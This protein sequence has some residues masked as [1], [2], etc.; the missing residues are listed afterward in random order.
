M[1]NKIILSKISTIGFKE[2]SVLLLLAM[3]VCFQFSTKAQDTE[4]TRPSW[5]FGVAAGSNF[6][7]YRGTTQNLNADLTVPSAFYNGFGAGLFIA[8]S[9]E[10]YKP[11]SVLGFIFQVGYDD[12]S[13]NFDQVT[14][15][16]NCPADL[17]TRTN[18]ISVEPSLRI[19]PFKN[20]FYVYGGPRLAFN[21][22]NSFKYQLGVNPDVPGQEPTPAVRGDLSNTQETI[23]SM[24]VGA[25]YDIMLSSVK[26]K[27]QFVLSP[28][29]AFHPYYGQNPRTSESW[30]I[31]TVR[32]GFVLKFGQG[33]QVP[34]LVEALPAI[35]PFSFSVNAP[36]N[37]NTEPIVSE[38]FPL[39][40]Y[41]FFDLGSTEIPARYVKLDKSQV[42]DFKEDQLETTKPINLSGRSDRGMIV[43]Y[44]ILNILGDRM[45]KNPNTTIKLVGA[46]EKGPEDGKLMAESVKKY[47]TS[48]FEIAPSRITVEG[49]TKPKLPSEQPGGTLE[50]ELLRQGDR[51][52]SI[53]S[54]SPEL[55]M[56]FQSGANA[57]L[58]PI[59][60]TGTKVAPQSSY[61]TFDLP[62][63]KEAFKVWN[64]EVKDEKG[65]IQHFGPYTEETASIP[66]K[67]ILGSREE[68]D[69]TIAMVGTTPDG[70]TVRE[71]KQAHVVLWKPS[72]NEESKRFSVIYDFNNSDAIKIYEDYLSKV[73]TPKI[74]K[75]GRVVINGFTDVIGD[76]TNNQELSLARANDVKQILEKSL[77]AAGRSDVTFVVTG[78]GENESLAPFDNKLPEERFYNR[79]V[80][81]DVFPAK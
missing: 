60:L 26:N 16:C 42:K 14:T 65:M 76:A 66:T 19:A 12:R 10:Y 44:N 80:I 77:K 32:A 79:T 55:L 24:Q 39:R 73:V 47:L 25:G 81:I 50:L 51:R 17:K 6:N 37:A 64:V 49:R 43:Y 33:K 36:S 52:V 31:T 45:Q 53:E 5:Y 27:T 54:A 74:P 58:K 38:T 69:Y 13:A 41:V 3:L 2:Q 57:P 35:K 18:Y 67:T 20:N 8:P 78:N 11:N 68:G 34:L 30:N 63:A 56:E 40:N 72:V 1:N 75:N 4:Y 9:I 21:L 23:I 59:V 28:F 29:V 46:S 71:E 7:F 48:I 70:Q 15:V 61:V 22:E 62:G